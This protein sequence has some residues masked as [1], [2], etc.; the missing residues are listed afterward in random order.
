MNNL[1]L[2]FSIITKEFKEKS[3]SYIGWA[4][5]AYNSGILVGPVIGSLIYGIGGYEFTF[6]CFGVSIFIAATL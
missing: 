4:E 6:I 2:G 5:T 3:D 1:N